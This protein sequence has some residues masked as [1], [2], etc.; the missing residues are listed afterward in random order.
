M[1][2]KPISEKVVAKFESLKTAPPGTHISIC[3]TIT[4]GNWHNQSVLVEWKETHL[5]IRHQGNTVSVERTDIDSLDH[6]FEPEKGLV[7]A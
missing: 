7:I 5:V 6:S 1:F 3:R 4:E 2:K